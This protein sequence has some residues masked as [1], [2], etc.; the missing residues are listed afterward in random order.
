MKRILIITAILTFTLGTI[1]AQKLKPNA[2]IKTSSS[3]FVTHQIEKSESMM[4]YNSKSIYHNKIPKNRNP[5]ITVERGDNSGMLKA[6]RQ[7]FSNDRLKELL[8]EKVL[9]MTFYLNPAGKVLEVEFLVDKNTTLTAKE[10]ESLEA[11]IKANVWFKLRPEEIKGEDFID[12][13]QGVRFSRVL[14][15]TLK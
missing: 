3:S 9:P 1:Y 11:A 14:D 13:G 15:G 7:V 10:L 6:F 12:I 2:V 4:V 5:D 8:P